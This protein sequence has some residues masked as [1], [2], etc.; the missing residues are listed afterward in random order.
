MLESFAERLEYFLKMKEISKGAFA[1]LLGVPQS[2]IS[3]YVKVGDDVS[4]PRTDVLLRMAETGCNIHWLITGEG[5][6]Y[7]ENEEGKKLKTKQ[8]AGQPLQSQQN[9]AAHQKIRLNPDLVPMRPEE[10]LLRTPIIDLNPGDA[11]VVEHFLSQLLLQLK[12]A[13]HDNPAYRLRDS[14]V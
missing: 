2:Q 12:T 3:R 13:S 8:E 7:A 5:A 10:T 1:D 11:A 9:G 6:M 14:P 4:L